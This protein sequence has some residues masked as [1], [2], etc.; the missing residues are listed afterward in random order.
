MFTPTRL[1][2]TLILL[3][4]SLSFTPA[5]QATS[6]SC[7]TK[8]ARLSGTEAL[9]IA[10]T[11][12]LELSKKRLPLEKQK[13]VQAEQSLAAASKALTT[14]QEG[15][16]EHTNSTSLVKT[17]TTTVASAKKKVDLTARAISA[18]TVTKNKLDSEL[19]KLRAD[20]KASKC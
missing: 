13:L 12:T 16:T 10:T 15:S 19:K 3:S 1:L 14:Y 4:L 18:S 11:K 7:V 2:S 5:A 17:L 9:A 6:F 8:Q 20:L